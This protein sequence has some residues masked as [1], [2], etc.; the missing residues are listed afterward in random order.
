MIVEMERKERSPNVIVMGGRVENYFT[1][2]SA[3]TRSF[4]REVRPSCQFNDP[5]VSRHSLAPVAKH[6]LNWPRDEF[7]IIPPLVA[8]PRI[9][10]SLEFIAAPQIL[11]RYQ[12]LQ[13]IVG[14][15]FLRWGDG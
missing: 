6:Q 1:D 10:I 9:E 11:S 3:F 8:F 14:P 7:R 15:P 2:N 4:A 12:P 13:I 5:Y